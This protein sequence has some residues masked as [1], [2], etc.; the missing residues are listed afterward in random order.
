MYLC[1]NVNCAEPGG[2]VMVGESNSFRPTLE[3]SGEKTELGA[4]SLEEDEVTQTDW[5][6][7]VDEVLPAGNVGAVWPS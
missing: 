2:S 6:P 4:V 1:R 7:L 3:G 5:A